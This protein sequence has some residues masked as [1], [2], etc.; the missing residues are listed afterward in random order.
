MRST[1]LLIALIYSGISLKA[2]DTT[3][4]SVSY[5]DTVKYINSLTS[6]YLGTSI[7]ISNSSATS[8]YAGYAQ[9]FEAPD[10]ITLNGFCFY[11]VIEGP[12]PDVIDA[13]L[14][15]PD[16]PGGSPGTLIETVSVTVPSFTSYTG[17]MNSSVI[18][19]CANFTSPIEIEGSYFLSIRNLTDVNMFIARNVDGNALATPSEFVYYH[20]DAGTFSGW[21]DQGPWG[22]GWQFNAI[23][24]PI[25]SYDFTAITIVNDSLFCAG[26]TLTLDLTVAEG[27]SAFF[28]KHYNPNFSTYTGLLSS[29]I[30]N[31]GDGSGNTVDTSHVYNA[32]GVFSIS[33]D[34]NIITPVWTQNSMIISCDGTVRVVDPSIDLGIDTSVCAGSIVN[35]DAGANSDSYLWQNMSTSSTLGV[36]TDTLLNGV[37]NYYVDVTK[38][39]CAA[40]D[41]VVLTVGD[42]IVDLGSDTTLCLNQGVTFTAG[43]FD[44]YLWNT[45]QTTETVSVGPFTGPSVETIIIEVTEGS[46]QG[47]DTLI[48]TVDNCLGVEEESQLQISLFPNP[49]NGNFN[50]DL[51][52][53]DAPNGNITIIDNMGRVVFMKNIT[54]QREEINIGNLTAGSYFVNIYVNGNQIMKKI[55]IIN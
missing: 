8:G 27:D 2:Q 1:L 34:F 30:V 21:Y 51:S 17:A 32:G 45:G 4:C 26:D 33:R 40:S 23:I 54:N 42:L 5:I 43:V 52:K 18:K 35:L 38:E 24:E 12:L 44:S 15:L 39:F 6:G 53:V 19:R 37:Y 16:G 22:A 50:I 10:T 7:N 3:T 55:Q 13:E 46:C 11:T 29:K 28:N 41:T 31:F 25:V 20:E 47:S 36:D 14:F 48:L 49:S 9:L